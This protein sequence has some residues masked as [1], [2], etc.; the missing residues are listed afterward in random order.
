MVTVVPTEGSKPVTRLNDRWGGVV[1]GG[2]NYRNLS[3][4]VSCKQDGIGRVHSTYHPPVTVSSGA[5]KACEISR[6]LIRYPIFQSLPS[7]PPPTTPQ[8]QEAKGRC[9]LSAIRVKT[10]TSEQAGLGVPVLLSQR[11]EN[12]PE[13]PR[14][15]HRTSYTSPISIPIYLYIALRMYLFGSKYIT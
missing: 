3:T 14:G 1:V 10:E 6:D 11:V 2:G 8:N 12:G 4:G 15:E 5:N 13:E 9:V 7:P